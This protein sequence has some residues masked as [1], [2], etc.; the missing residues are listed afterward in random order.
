MAR[1]SEKNKKILRESDCE[2]KKKKENR[3]KILGPENLLDKPP[4]KK[5]PPPPPT[6]THKHTDTQ[7]MMLERVRKLFSFEAE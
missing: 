5:G 4:I 1:C 2:R 6:P 7:T 3:I